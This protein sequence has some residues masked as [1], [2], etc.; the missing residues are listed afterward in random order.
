MSVAVATITF[1]VARSF[2]FD[3]GWAGSFSLRR[4]ARDFPLLDTRPRLDAV[5]QLLTGLFEF[6]DRLAQAMAQ[7]GEPFGPEKQHRDSQ[8]QK[9]DRQMFDTHAH[10]SFV[11]SLTDD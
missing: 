5:G 3:D 11:L 1:R 8:Q 7:L 10:R 6:F 4:G 9:Q 2:R